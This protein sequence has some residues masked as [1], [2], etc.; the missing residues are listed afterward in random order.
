MV[1]RDTPNNLFNF[2][3]PTVEEILAESVNN[4]DAVA[5]LNSTQNTLEFKV[6][7]EANKNILWLAHITLSEA[8]Y[9]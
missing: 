6:T 5:S 4:W 3:N 9:S 2:I 8:D 7:G 1:E